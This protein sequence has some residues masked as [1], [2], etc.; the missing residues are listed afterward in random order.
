MPQG[1]SLFTR[2]R[3]LGF[4]LELVPRLAGR[5]CDALTLHLWGSGTKDRA[6]STRRNL[7]MVNSGKTSA[8]NS[9]PSARPDHCGHSDYFSGHSEKAVSVGQ[10]STRFVTGCKSRNLVFFRDRSLNRVA[11]FEGWDRPFGEAHGAGAVLGSER[12]NRLVL[13]E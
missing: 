1:F 10:I 6:E 8:A 13:Y 2:R 9:G 7:G 12:K 11:Y 4:W 3:C 5:R